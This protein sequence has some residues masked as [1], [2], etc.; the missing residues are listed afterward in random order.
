MAGGVAV[1]IGGRGIMVRSGGTRVEGNGPGREA[2]SRPEGDAEVP[3][4]R[5]RRQTG[6]ADEPTIFS[7]VFTA[8]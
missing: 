6:R 8:K 1:M 3:S 7:A 4:G 5:D 2:D